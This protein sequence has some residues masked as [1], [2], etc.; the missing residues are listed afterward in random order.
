MNLNFCDACTPPKGHL[1]LQRNLRWQLKNIY[2]SH[3]LSCVITESSPLE[4]SRWHADLYV[5]IVLLFSF[6]LEGLSPLSAST[7][8]GLPLDFFNQKL[9]NCTEAQGHPG[10]TLGW[11]MSLQ[12]LTGS[13]YFWLVL[14]QAEQVLRF[15]KLILTTHVKPAHS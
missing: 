11:P 14:L 1:H 5:N 10:I 15:S 13:W 3:W 12:V 7:D 6:Y 9:I 2:I 8:G 4:N